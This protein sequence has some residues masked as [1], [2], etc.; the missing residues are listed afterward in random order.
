MS[1][2]LALVFGSILLAL[3]FFFSILIMTNIIRSQKPRT[4]AVT[5][6]LLFLLCTIGAIV[7]T[8]A[9]Y[10]INH[11]VYS[12]YD[13]FFRQQGDIASSRM[14]VDLL[15]QPKYQDSLRLTRFEA[16]VYSQNGED[17][18]IAEIFNRIGTTNKYFVEFGSADGTENN[19]V[20]LLSQ[21]WS[22]LWLDGDKDAIARVHEHFA[23]EIKA[24]RL[25]A[26]ASFIT[27]ENIEQLFSSRS[28]PKDLDLL[29]ID[30]DRNDYHVWKAIGA[31]RPRVVVIEYNAIFSPG[32]EWVVDYKA[33][34]WWDGTANFGAS[35]SALETLGRLKGYSLVGCTVAGVNAF[36]VRNDVLQNKFCAPYTA[37]NHY[38]PTRYWMTWGGHPRSL[39]R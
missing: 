24:R 26:D 31:Y 30:I 10:G 7:L 8:A 1:T 11:R 16:K 36:F 35:L 22:G 3:F 27:A 38:E 5:R 15:S 2:T 19:S 14:M 4:G 32:I 37:R 13:N 6:A 12:L 18:I 28:V 21:G 9:F 33:D 29:S 23:P 17:G 39:N 20:F 25:T 34:A